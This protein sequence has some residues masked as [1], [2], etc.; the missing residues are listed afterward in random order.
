MCARVCVCKHTWKASGWAR[1]KRSKGWGVEKHLWNI[2]YCITR[3]PFFKPTTFWLVAPQPPPHQFHVAAIKLVGLF[4]MSGPTKSPMKLKFIWAIR[5]TLKDKVV[6]GSLSG[7]GQIWS[8]CIKRAG[9]TWLW[10]IWVWVKACRRSATFHRVLSIKNKFFLIRKYDV[11]Q[12]QHPNFKHTENLSFWFEATILGNHFLRVLQRWTYSL[13][14][15]CWL[16]KFNL[17]FQTD[18]RC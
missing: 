15:V 11:F 18:G 3:T 13:D 4:I 17:A 7:N 8:Q 1:F 5:G 9:D 14:F 16:P 2:S 12:I 6:L 10:G